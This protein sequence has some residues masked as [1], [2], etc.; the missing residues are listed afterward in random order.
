VRVTDVAWDARVCAAIRERRLL[1]FDYDGKHRVT[2][3]Y[4][5]GVQHDREAVRA[6]LQ[7]GGRH[8]SGRLR[9]REDVD[10]RRR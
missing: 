4:C 3:P 7:V 10:D 8:A 2:E 5:H 1:E 6:A 9:F